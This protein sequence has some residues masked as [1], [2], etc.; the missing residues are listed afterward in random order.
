MPIAPT[1]QLSNTATL[2]KSLT[3]EVGRPVTAVYTVRAVRQLADRV[4]YLVVTRGDRVVI[5]VS[6]SVVFSLKLLL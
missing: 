5:P 6:R 1:T 2:R 4:L 3:L